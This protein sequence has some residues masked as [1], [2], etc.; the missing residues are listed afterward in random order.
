MQSQH[1]TCVKV[2]VN[3]AGEIARLKTALAEIRD[4]PFSMVNDSESLRH[5]CR[6]MQHI[7]TE[8]LR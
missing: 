8:A 3:Q 7:A 6:V 4:T 5:S 1:D 2:T